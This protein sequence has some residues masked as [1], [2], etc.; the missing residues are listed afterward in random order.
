MPVV[1]MVGQVVL[2]TILMLVPGILFWLGVGG[3]AV[4]AARSGSGC[5]ARAPRQRR[6]RRAFRTAG[7]RMRR[8]LAAEGIPP[9]KRLM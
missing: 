1:A 6:R 8:G 9:V 4:V 3:L 7:Q 2:A 5:R